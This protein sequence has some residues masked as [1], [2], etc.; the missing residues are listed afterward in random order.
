M[1]EICPVKT[2]ILALAFVGVLL[3]ES[4][5]ASDVVT[6]TDENFDELTEEGVWMVEIYAPCE[7]CPLFLFLDSECFRSPSHWVTPPFCPGCTHCKDLEP[8]WAQ[9]ATELKGKV[10]VGKVSLSCACTACYPT[11]CDAT[12]TLYILG[13]ERAMTC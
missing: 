11:V 2:K 7:S 13:A 9:L 5:L 4:T 12:H 8:T 10:H 3:C 1:F 6:I